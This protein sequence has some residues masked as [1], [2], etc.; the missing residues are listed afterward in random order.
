[1]L[2]SNVTNTILRITT[3]MTVFTVVWKF[4]SINYDEALRFNREDGGI[5]H[6]VGWHLNLSGLFGMT[7]HK[8]TYCIS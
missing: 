3:P 4:H 8:V 5:S 6:H 7:F 2:F 1:M